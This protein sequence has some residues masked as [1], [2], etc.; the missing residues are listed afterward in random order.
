MST[1][2]CRGER[3]GD[4]GMI[5]RGEGEGGRGWNDT[6]CSSFHDGETNIHCHRTAGTVLVIQIMTSL[7]T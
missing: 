1:Y 4:G 7:L 6:S 2:L 3:E 5:R